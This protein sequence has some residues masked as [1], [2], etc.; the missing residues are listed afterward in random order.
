MDQ[1]EEVVATGRGVK[2]TSKSEVSKIV[3]IRQFVCV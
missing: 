2:L 1:L 3:L